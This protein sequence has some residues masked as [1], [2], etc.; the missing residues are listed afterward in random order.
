M[1]APT[2]HPS[3]EQLN[4]YNLG[5]LP[6]EEAVA[7]ESHLSQCG[8]CCE[9]IVSF[10]SDDTFVGLLQEARQLLP[11]Q[12]IDQDGVNAT[13]ASRSQEIPA[14]LIEHPRYEMIGL[15][16]K[17]GMGDVYKA[18]HRM[19]DRTVALK[20][21]NRD[22]TQKS[23][24]VDRFHREVKAAAQLSHPNIVT[25]HDAEQAGELHFMVMEY[26]DGVDLAR[27]VKE[28]GAL[29]I[30]EAC[31]YVRQAASGLQ[32]AHELG[33]VHR[34]IKPHN[35]MVTNDG[36][37]KILDFG[38]ASLAPDSVADADTVEAHGDLTVAGAIMGTPDF[39]S[40]EQA[41]DARQ[42]DI[43]SDI[44]SLG[45]TLYCLLAGRPPF[46]DGSV[47]HKLES[48][49][50]VEP[51]PLQSLRDDIP[52][53]VVA[54][55]SKMMAKNPNERFQTP[56]EVASALEP[57]SI[58][59][60][61]EKTSPEQQAKPV[62]KRSLRWPLIATA[63]LLIATIIAGFPHFFSPEEGASDDRPYLVGGGAGVGGD[64]WYFNSG[65][66]YLNR[67]EPGVLFGMYEDP[68]GNRALSYVVI[69]R[70]GID[71]FSNVND[72]NVGG[73][74]FDGE[75][76]SI[77]D[78][79]S[80]DGKGVEL[81]FKFQV[82]E[83]KVNTSK[84]GI[85][86]KTLDAADGNLLLVDMTQDVVTWSQVHARLP[87]DLPDPRDVTSST[88]TV[89]KLAQQIT[90]QLARKNLPQ[91]FL[92]GADI[93]SDDTGQ[94]RSA[95][96]GK[97][98]L[99]PEIAQL[100]A[101]SGKSEAEFK[102]TVHT[103]ISQAASIPNAQ[104]EKFATDPRASLDGIE[105]QPLSLV[106]LSQR[107]AAVNQ[108]N[109]NDL[110]FR[111]LSQRVPKPTA[112][113]KA[114]SLS[115]PHG[116]V[117]VIQPE[118]IKHT[119]L[120]IDAESKGMR[121]S[122][123][124]ESPNLYAGKVDFL[125]KFELGRMQIVKFSLPHSGITIAR[126]D[127]NIWWRQTDDDNSAQ[128]SNDT[129]TVVPAPLDQIRETLQT[130]ANVAEQ[131]DESKE[132]AQKVRQLQQDLYKNKTPNTESHRKVSAQVAE[133]CWPSLSDSI[134]PSMAVVIADLT[135]PDMSVRISDRLAAAGRPTEP[136]GW[137]VQFVH[138]LAL[139]RA[140]KIDEALKE[141]DLLTK[142]IDINLRKGRLPDLKLRFLDDSRSQKSLL[143][144]ARLQKALILAIA[145]KTGEAF[146]VSTAAGAVEVSN[147]TDDDQKAIQSMLPML[148]KAMADEKP[149]K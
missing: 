149:N 76:A 40:P 109:S 132:L 50:R 1:P 111:M 104:W 142:K 34:D 46:T 148:A 20:I 14:R 18:R 21:I 13:T 9:T 2:T 89:E 66:T 133:V 143:K 96:S 59:R 145:G 128:S 6:P 102:R 10:S 88:E 108:D 37:V 91:E 5:Q 147:P 95:T 93:S 74:T 7:I 26:V 61:V 8:P 44:Y 141:N 72:S 47:M 139:A 19:M 29:P 55:I 70:H 117:S 85:N 32:Q 134:P 22:L 86:G 130:W 16:G 94:D 4:A 81:E 135:K 79:I 146:D 71:D 137:D 39:I 122:V 58:G 57:V 103:V 90:D 110:S 56:A 84:M 129:K 43:R 101:K 125:M 11:E 24:A 138:A 100:I 114:M 15:I 106:L 27:T 60:P 52:A 53:E 12:T 140:G 119:Q 83:S 28:R 82:D 3:N 73:M 51:E 124:F 25:A 107:P 42:A 75:V 62:R 136:V 99:S 31:D 127:Q 41:E 118:Y 65:S 98:D 68:S 78:G 97:W 121:G 54:V 67:D 126:D 35:L 92:A 30:A 45:A 113:H 115:R 38:L 64:G 36:T 49:A 144:Q 120:S 23:E 80:I 87:K 33:M 112:L 17:G 77:K 69:L 105:G 123:E 63:I 131:S 116:Y 48:H